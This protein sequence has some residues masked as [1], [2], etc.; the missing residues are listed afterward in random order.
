MTYQILE[1]TGNGEQRVKLSTDDIV[2]AERRFD[3]LRFRELGSDEFDCS[4]EL[5][6]AWGAYM[7]GGT[8]RVR[9]WLVTIQ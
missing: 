3:I 6:A 8:D 7:Q 4:E 1:A 2:L 9:Y 5:D